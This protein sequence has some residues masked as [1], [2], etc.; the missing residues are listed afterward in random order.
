MTVYNCNWKLKAEKI[1]WNGPRIMCS[2]GLH[3]PCEQRF[4]VVEIGY[5]DK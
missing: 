1:R 4:F 2:L 5:I 3:A